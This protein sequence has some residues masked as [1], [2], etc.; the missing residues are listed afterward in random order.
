MHRL[1]GQRA[2]LAA[3]RGDHPARQVEV[4]AL[5]GA[6]M[7]LDRDQLL[8]ADEA[9]PA[10]ERLGVVGRIG[11]VGGHVLAHDLRGVARDVEA[12]LEAVLQPHAR[13]RLRLDPGPRTPMGLDE[14]VCLRN[15]FLVRHGSV[16]N[17]S[18]K[19]VHPG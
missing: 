2:E 13:H 3:Q 12:G 11:V 6:E 19:T 16:L 5:G 7:L 8:L 18:G 17:P 14:P 4:A 15:L 1:V 9:V 10:A